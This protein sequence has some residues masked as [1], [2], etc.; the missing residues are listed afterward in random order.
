[1]NV[2]I[3]GFQVRNGNANGSGTNYTGVPFAGPANERSAGGGAYI[4]GTT[5]RVRNCYFFANRAI[6]EGG[7]L[8]FRGDS[9]GGEGV[10]ISL[11]TF[12]GNTALIGGGLAL[13]RIGDFE[14]MELTERSHIHNCN[15]WRNLAIA[16]QIDQ[17]AGGGLWVGA[18]DSEPL[19][20][21]NV[22]FAGNVTNGVGSAACVATELATV[23]VPISPVRFGHCTMTQNIVIGEGTSRGFTLF[24]SSLNLPGQ[25]PEDIRNS[26]LWGNTDRAGT[27][28]AVGP[29]AVLTNPQLLIRHSNV[30]R[31][32]TAVVP[33][34][35]ANL[36]TNPFF[37]SLMDLR[38]QA[39]S[40]CVD[41]G[42]D[43]LLLPDLA[44]LNGNQN[45]SEAVPFDLSANIVRSIDDLGVTP[46]C[47]GVTPCGVTDMGA[48]EREP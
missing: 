20:V 30:Q 44:D 18:R 29:D 22:L 41:S 4:V 25:A 16:D 10:G 47:G 42:S 39:A 6:A 23:L 21:C 28:D 33:S 43:A 19:D 38:L 8:L 37:I 45:Y 17:A 7:G 11:S 2:V 26:I 46:T 40:P 3:D 9:E 1:M 27:T 5:I 31:T 13:R 24:Y 36:N 12:F 35:F 32:G 34:G 15:I 14:S 48:Y